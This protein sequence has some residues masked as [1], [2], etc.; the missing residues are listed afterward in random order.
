M[1][2]KCDG[3]SKT[4]RSTK[5]NGQDSCQV[6]EK[7]NSFFSSFSPSRSFF[8]RSNGI[9]SL[10]VNEIHRVHQMHIYYLCELDESKNKRERE[11]EFIL[12]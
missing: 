8:F 11:K 4:S 3:S 6:R 9:V 5:K 7:N 1:E 2:I 10:N 12:F